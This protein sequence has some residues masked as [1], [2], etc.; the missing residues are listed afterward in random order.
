MEKA[1]KAKELEKNEAVK[2]NINKR[3]SSMG[4]DREM[5]NPKDIDYLAKIEEVITEKFQQEQLATDMSKNN[6]IS[7]IG[8]SKE[9]KIARQTLYN[10][11]IL[12]EYIETAQKEFSTVSLTEKLEKAY[13]EISQLREQVDAYQKRDIQLEEMR[14]EI[15]FLEKELDKKKKLLNYKMN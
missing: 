4:V 7:L 14:R 10:K 3:L 6:K 15:E 13:A 12:G 11:Q 5:V 8:I 9:A 1:V 2:K